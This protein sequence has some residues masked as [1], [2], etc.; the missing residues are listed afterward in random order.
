MKPDECMLRWY[1]REGPA[2]LSGAGAAL[3]TLVGNSAVRP[4]IGATTAVFDRSLY[5]LRE[6]TQSRSFFQFLLFVRIH[7]EIFQIFINFSALAIPS[8]SPY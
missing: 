2:N 7:P 6:R 8:V 4:A 5:L 3:A 1:A